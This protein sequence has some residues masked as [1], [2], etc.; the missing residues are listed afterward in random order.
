MVMAMFLD[1]VIVMSYDNE[2]GSSCDGGRFGMVVLILI[3]LFPIIVFL[4]HGLPRYCV[5]ACG[6]DEV[7]GA[8]EC[9]AAT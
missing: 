2:M 3:R 1:C 5:S 4:S 8:C 6:A 9:T 7:D